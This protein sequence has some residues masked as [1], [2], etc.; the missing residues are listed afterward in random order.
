MRVFGW[1]RITAYPRPMLSAADTCNIVAHF[2]RDTVLTR[3]GR[4]RSSCSDEQNRVNT[5]VILRIVCNL[6][7]FAPDHLSCVRDQP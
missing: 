2:I 4:A 6:G 7:V 1:P 3:P 5:A